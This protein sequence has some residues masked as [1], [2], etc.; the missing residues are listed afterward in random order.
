MAVKTRDEILAAIRSRLGDD[1]SDDALTIIEDIEDTFKDYEIR[2]GEDWKGKYDELDAQWRKRYRDR[3]FQKADNK[4][5][6]PD[7]V[8]DD[9]Q[10]DLKEEGKVKDFDELFTEKEDNSGY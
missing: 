10:K 2:A 6:T 4:E 3:F 5:T 9:N 7:G 8:K 1:T